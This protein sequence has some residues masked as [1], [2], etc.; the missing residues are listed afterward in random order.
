MTANFVRK[1]F[2]ECTGRGVKVAIIDSGVNPA[3]PH[4]G[5]VAG[6]VRIGPGDAGTSNDYLDY[7]GHGTAVAGAIREKAPDAQLYAVKV[8]DRVLTTN[9]DAIVKA[10]DW[11]ADSEIDVIN[12]SLGTTNIEHYNALQLALDR[13]AK[14]GEVNVAAREMSGND[15]LPGCLPAV[16]GVAVDWHCARADYGVHIVDGDATFIASA[17]PREIPGVPRERNLNGISFAVANMSGFVARA[18]EMNP[19]A[20][21]EVLT[22]LLIE[23]S[24]ALSESGR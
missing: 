11:C 16:I 24:V 17:Y 23:E 6:G 8:F 1:P 20:T 9:I 21:I 12:L 2:A 15:S 18:K 14:L 19:P 7:I 10:I 22:R 13:A 3:H 4:V 5:G